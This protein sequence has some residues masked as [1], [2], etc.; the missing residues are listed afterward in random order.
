MKRSFRP[1]DL[2]DY[3]YSWKDYINE[4][5]RLKYFRRKCGRPLS[6]VL[7]GPVGWDGILKP[8][9]VRSIV[10]LCKD[11]LRL[12]SNEPHRLQYIGRFD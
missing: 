7:S 11:S 3:I 5:T 4:A 9:D 2:Y 12:A 1:V 8:P 6:S 10:D